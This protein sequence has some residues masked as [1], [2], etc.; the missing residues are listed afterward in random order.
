M[1]LF[2]SIEIEIKST[3][4]RKGFAAADP[5]REFG[6]FI[7]S[8]KEFGNIFELL[9]ESRTIHYVTNG[10]FSAHDLLFSLLEKVGPAKV[11]LTTWTM[12]EFPAK[13]L[14][15]AL[16]AGLITEL[17]CLLDVRMEK[18]PNVLQLMKFNASKIK[19][20]NCHAKVMIILTKSISYSI[21]SSQNLT[22]NPRMEAGVITKSTEIATFHTEWIKKEIFNDGT[23]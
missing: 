1:S 16:S 23:Y 9:N 12:T 7:N 6:V 17:N 19:L 3:E 2:G 14:I 4:I 13:R 11:Y 15:E 8:A 10:A 18:N 21:V 5:S 20:T 22:E